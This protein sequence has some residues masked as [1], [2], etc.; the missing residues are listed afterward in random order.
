[1]LDHA[2]A[3]LWKAPPD[4]LLEKVAALITESMPTWEG[5]ASDLVIALQIDMAPNLMVRKL[6]VSKSVLV[7]QYQI[8]YTSR[9]TKTGCVVHIRRVEATR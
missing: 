1:M 7:D 4:P 2:E 3:Q 6:N 8:E 9:R 5:R